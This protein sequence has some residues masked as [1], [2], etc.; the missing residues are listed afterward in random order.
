MALPTPDTLIP[1]IVT[2]E[3]A[4]AVLE[5]AQ[6]ANRVTVTS[7]DG[8]FIAIAD[9]NVALTQVTIAQALFDAGDPI[10]L[11][12]GVMAVAAQALATANVNMSAAATADAATYAL[13]G[14]P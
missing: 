9:G 6:R 1:G 12:N 13:P 7:A 10:G 3:H 11:P 4:I 8:N 2:V 5:A 14:L